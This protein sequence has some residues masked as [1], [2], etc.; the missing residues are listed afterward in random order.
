MMIQGDLKENYSQY[1]MPQLDL[2]MLFAPFLIYVKLSPV[3]H[4]NCSKQQRQK[5]F[6]L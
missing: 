5:I 4:V 2:L 3:I 6:H 1:F